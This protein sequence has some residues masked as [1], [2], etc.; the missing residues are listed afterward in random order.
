M[1][2]DLKN[3]ILTGDEKNLEKINELED[4]SDSSEDV[5]K[6]VQREKYVRSTASAEK[7]HI[8]K[9]VETLIYQNDGI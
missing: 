5:Q 8:P 9:F 3:S 2:S 6:E 7:M 4:S 1:T